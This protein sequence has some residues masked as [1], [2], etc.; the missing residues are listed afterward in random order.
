MLEPGLSLSSVGMVGAEGKSRRQ[1]DSAL[2]LGLPGA[3]SL[4][5]VS[6]AHGSSLCWHGGVNVWQGSAEGYLSHVPSQAG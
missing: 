3:S 6:Y 4:P 5:R 1:Q 2:G